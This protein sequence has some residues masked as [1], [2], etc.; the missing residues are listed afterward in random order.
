[1]KKTLMFFVA[2]LLFSA[3][4]VAEKTVVIDFALLNADA[5]DGS[6]Q[7]ARTIMDFG[8]VAGS[9]YDND[10]KA[11]M[12]T[13]LAISEW[14]VVLNSSS[15]NPIAV[16]V[17]HA[18]E[19][20]VSGEA[21]KYTGQKLMGVRINFPVWASNANA[22]IKPSFLIPVYERLNEGADE[23]KSDARRF[24]GGYGVVRN[25]GVI[26]SISV[27]TYG[28]NFPHGLY[29]ILRNQNDEVKRYFMGYLLFDEWRELVWNNPN[30]VTQ[31]K[32]REVRIYP[33][34]P[35]ELPFVTFEGFLV[36]R[37]ASHEGGDFVGYFKDVNIIYDKAVL[38]TVRDFADEDIWGIQSKRNFDRKRIEVARFG[39]QQ[40]LRF[41]EKEKMAKESGF[42]S[43]KEDEGAPAQASSQNDAE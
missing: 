41:L 7:N 39:Q 16:A 24:E 15:R 36:T 1:M 37:D 18:A 20:E 33:A 34:Y 6:G 5:E 38:N 14:E 9:G 3:A 35:T 4:L 10:Q 40:V 28:M 32:S 25:V 8:A 23:K 21:Q 26:K 11:M 22:V 27:N 17:S 43:V 42:D 19:A 13:S 29:V 31:V 2:A 12:R 30:Y